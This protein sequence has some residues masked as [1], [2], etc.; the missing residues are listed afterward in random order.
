M[1]R[2]PSGPAHVLL[3]VERILLGALGCVGLIGGLLLLLWGTPPLPIRLIGGGMFA[4]TGLVLVAVAT[5]VI[6][7]PDANSREYREEMVERA[8]RRRKGQTYK[9]LN[10]S[11]K[12]G[13]A[14]RG[15]R[16][17]SVGTGRKKNEVGEGRKRP[18]LDRGSSRK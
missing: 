14:A 17:R 11:P 13:A 16:R 3:P 4:L 6:H 5:G 12:P 15:P 10:N 2:T 7:P 8:Q 18:Q 1:P 9:T